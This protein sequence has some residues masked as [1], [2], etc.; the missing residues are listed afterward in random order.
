L[1]SELGDWFCWEWN[2]ESKGLKGKVF[3]KNSVLLLDFYNL[4]EYLLKTES[5]L[6]WISTTSHPWKY[7]YFTTGQRPKDSWRQIITHTEKW[8]GKLNTSY[9][10]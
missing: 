4:I 9:F 1:M 2:C 5:N 6:P 10:S 3:N 7:F 8:E